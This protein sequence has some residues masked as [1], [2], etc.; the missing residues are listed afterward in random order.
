MAQDLRY[1]IRMKWTNFSKG[2]MSVVQDG[3]VLQKQLEEKSADLGLAEKAAVIKSRR[4][5]QRADGRVVHQLRV[6]E[7]QNI[8]DQLRLKKIART[9]GSHEE[10]PC[11]GTFIGPKPEMQS[12][13]TSNSSIRPTRFAL[14]HERCNPFQ[15]N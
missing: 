1:T 10:G 14:G 3:V 8:R 2:N 6:L 12:A 7:R 4:R 5:G 11:R 13:S 9:K 15:M